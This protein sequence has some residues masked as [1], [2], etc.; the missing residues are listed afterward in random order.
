MSEKTSRGSE[1]EIIRKIMSDGEARAARL[2]DNAGRSVEGE[3]RKAEAEAEKV[4]NEMLGQVKRKV[5]TLKSKE[6]A[7]GHIEAKRVLLRSREEA[8]SKVFDTILKELDNLHRDGPRY[9]EALISLAVEAVGAIGEKEVTVTLGK[10]DE[11][12]ADEKLVSDIGGRLDSQGSPG[13]A[14]EIVV[15]PS[16][17]GGGCVAG[18][19]DLRII[20]D[21][22][23]KRRLDRL[24]PSLRST[25]VSEVLKS[26]G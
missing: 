17:E 15:D 12:L 16:L 7:G 26:D 24:K 25:I 18:S 21:N 1:D 23:F 5:E 14:I 6:I 13:I 2:L 4:R 20:F 22:T 11:N 19:K 8:I 3:S 9:R 10:D